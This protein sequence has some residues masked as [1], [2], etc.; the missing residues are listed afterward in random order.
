MTDGLPNQFHSKRYTCGTAQFEALLGGLLMLVA[1]SRGK[2]A[3]KHGQHPAGVM[4]YNTPR[5]H[6]YRCVTSTDADLSS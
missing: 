6:N 4:Q 5:L 1:Q 2:G 3:H